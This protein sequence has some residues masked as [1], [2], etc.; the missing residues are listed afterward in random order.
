ML[1]I[2]NHVSIPDQEIELSAIRAQGAGGQNVNKVSSAIHLRFDI[3]ASSLPDFYK[4]RLLRLRDNRITREGVIVIK[5][6]NHRD[7]ER[8]REEALQRLQALIRSVAVTRKRRI[9][10][11]PSRASQQR[12]LDNKGK[13]GQQKALRRKPVI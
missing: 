4:Q 12:R 13:R 5:A 11:K 9:P 6:Q 3:N 10:T 8:N 7:R 1:I 2:S